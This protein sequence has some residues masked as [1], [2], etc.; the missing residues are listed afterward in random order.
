MT[1][2]VLRSN[3][4]SLLL[5][6]IDRAIE[7]RKPDKKV[8]ER[9]ALLSKS[10]LGLAL[11]GTLPAVDTVVARLM[12]AR[13]DVERWDAYSDEAFIRRL[14]LS[15]IDAFLAFGDDRTL[16][17]P[18]RAVAVAASETFSR[19]IKIPPAYRRRLVLAQSQQEGAR[20]AAW[21]DAIGSSEEQVA[22]ACS[23]VR[24]ALYPSPIMQLASLKGPD[25]DTIEPTAALLLRG[26]ETVQR[27]DLSASVGRAPASSY[28]MSQG[29]AKITSVAVSNLRGIGVSLELGLLRN[30]RPAS[31]LIYGD[32]GVGKSSLVDAIEFALQGRVGRTQDFNSPFAPV[33]NNLKTGESATAKVVLSDGTEVSRSLAKSPSGRLVADGRPPTAGFRWAPLTLKRSDL[34]RFLDTDPLSRGTVFF[35][36][37]P[38]DAEAMGTRPDE[39]L[40][41][42]EEELFAL[43]VR[44]QAQARTLAA[45]LGVPHDLVASPDQLE[46]TLRERLFSGATPKEAVNNGTWDALDEDLRRMIASL[47]STFAEYRSTKNKIERGVQILNPKAYEAQAKQL[48]EVMREIGA[49]VTASFQ[50]VAKADY[51]KAIKVFAGETG[52]V[53]LDVVVE[54]KN[55]ESAFPQQIFSEGYRDL[56]ALLFFVAVAQASTRRR[57][58]KVL[59][60]DDVFQSVDAGVRLGL[61]AHILSEM[62]DWQLII[63]LHDRL[64]YEQLRALM[65]RRGSNFVEHRLINWTFDSGPVFSAAMP[66]IV[67]GLDAALLSTDAALTCAAAGRLLETIASEESWRFRISVKRAR[68]D[69]YTLNDL[70]PGLA[71][72]LKRSS[73]R[74]LVR[75]IDDAADLRNLV[76]AHYNDFGDSLSWEEARRFG[77]NVRSLFRGLR[78]DTCGDWLFGKSDTIATC[79]CGN[80]LLQLREV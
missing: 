73:L 56:L 20:S 51:V 5:M 11:R 50:K 41:L 72:Y 19:I 12:Y 25:A 54:L 69:K 3:D 4:S 43:R 64:W 16:G 6:V 62:P 18:Q 2:S 13:R 42:L 33:L 58:A 34:L 8:V 22:E 36:Y 40:V 38:A 17:R 66:S 45:T 53:S 55:G 7:A 80:I 48:A 68:D 29:K 63:T 23:A 61:M 65:Q 75:E 21:A 24:A 77:E 52:P 70:W 60:L 28:D 35:D 78:C 67:A 30:G 1:G 26:A 9:Y 10:K 44:R 46:K 31:A 76:G 15:T 57:Q 37:F 49:E 32:N 39:Q 27:S 47:R 79:S 59:V 74:D 71:K 14:L